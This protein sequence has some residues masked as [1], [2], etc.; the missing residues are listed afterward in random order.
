MRN[1][2]LFALVALFIVLAALPSVAKDGLDLLPGDAQG[3]LTIDNM[4]R[5]YSTLGILEL[6][7]EYPDEF[8]FLSTEIIE[9]VGIDL[10][11]PAALDA[12]GFDLDRP[13]HIGILTEPPAVVVL[14]PGEERALKWVRAKME[15]QGLRFTNDT[16]HKGVSIEADEAD[17]VACFVRD[18]YIGVVITN[19]EEGGGPAM[20]TAKG[21]I[22][23]AGD[24]TM[25]SSERYK[26]TMGKLPKDADLRVFIGPEL[27]SH[28]SKWGTSEEQLAEHGMSAED[29]ESW[30][31]MLGIEDMV[32]GSA[33]TLDADR[34]TINSYVWMGKDAAVRRWVETH[35]DPVPF[36]RRL[37]SQPW[38]IGLG[39]V[40]MAAIWQDVRPLLDKMPRKEGEPSVEEELAEAK[41]EL[42]ID[43]EADIFNQI[44]GNLGL[45]VNSASMMGSDVVL[46][47]QV[48]DPDRFGKVVER[49][50]ALAREDAA[51]KAELHPEK[52]PTEIVEEE[53]NGATVYRI[54]IP[55]MAMLC[56]GV[57][58]DHFILTS[59]AGRFDEIALG[60]RGFIDEAESAEVRAGLS[61]P[62]SGVFYVDFKA[63]SRDAEGVLPMLGPTGVTISQVLAEL[64]E[65]VA[66]THVEKEGM[67]EVVTLTST[68]PG[69][70]KHIVELYISEMDIPG[71]D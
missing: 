20:G 33:V 46:L 1:R 29:V 38:M 68:R 57:V 21:L 27:Q 35:A 58:D 64:S 10:L 31:E 63:L 59:T 3:V 56:Y 17:E 51:K 71:A 2:F 53:V 50:T 66:V 12:E 45:L 55:P 37:P 8:G 6:R 62:K 67:D 70:W 11:D 25:D 40:N 47:A 15:E 9:D 5:L 60:G 26:S 44:D 14:I 52:P 49:L 39:R 13:L 54:A 42:G 30:Y 65:L 41:D 43:I 22:E 32:T 61:D 16:K 7:N 19:H 24:G 18:S 4:S 34:L 28:L 48:A 36:L 69:I 23:G